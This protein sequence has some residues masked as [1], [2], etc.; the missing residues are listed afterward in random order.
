MKN[1]LYFLIILALITACS[2]VTVV[3]YKNV[4]EIKNSTLIY[5]LPKQKIQVHT[6][7]VRTSYQCGPY[8]RFAK[9]YLGIDNQFTEHTVLWRISDL[10]FETI[11]IPDTTQSYAILNARKALQGQLN[12]SRDGRLLSV[13]KI[14]EGKIKGGKS[15]IVNLKHEDKEKNMFTDLSVK[16]ILVTKID[17]IYKR[18]R[19]DS[20]FVKVPQINDIIVNKNLE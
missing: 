12:F 6:Q 11:S 10:N 19:S 20:G 2:S 8:N 9:K 5:T 15:T 16:K 7:L 18:V 1:L 13:N 17:T 4:Q 14:S 3:P